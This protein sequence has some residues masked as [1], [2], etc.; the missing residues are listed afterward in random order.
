MDSAVFSREVNFLK[1]QSYAYRIEIASLKEEDSGEIIVSEIR[2]LL[3][4]AE[5]EPFQ[6]EFSEELFT[7][8]SEKII[9]YDRHLIG[10]QLKCGL[11]LKEELE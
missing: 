6:E 3:K 9:V 8:F 4:F 11:I 10:F 7:E 2:K 5:K 1:K